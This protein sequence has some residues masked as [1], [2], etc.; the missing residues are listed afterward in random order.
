M[1]RESTHHENS[2]SHERVADHVTVLLLQAR[3]T[4]RRDHRRLLQLLSVVDSVV[5]VAEETLSIVVE[6]AAGSKTTANSSAANARHRRRDG[7]VIRH[8]M[9]GSP[10]DVTEG[11]LSGAKMNHDLNGWIGSGILTGREESRHCLGWKVATRTTPCLAL[12]CRVLR[13]LPSTLRD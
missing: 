5:V 1:I 12:T 6:E 10:R 7:D 4:R 13:L 3:H 11:G 8:E 9:A 2:T